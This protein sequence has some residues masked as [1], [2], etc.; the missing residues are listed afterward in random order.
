MLVVMMIM[1]VMKV[2]KE[3]GE[4]AFIKYDDDED[5][6]TCI[7][8]KTVIPLTKN[9]VFLYG[10]EIAFVEHKTKIHLIYV[11]RNM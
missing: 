8:L 11:K 7:I 3:Q 1:G 10:E 6:Y 5:K 4:H 2:M 9:Y